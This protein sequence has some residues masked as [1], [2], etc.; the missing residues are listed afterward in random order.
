MLYQP[1]L[2]TWAYPSIC[3]VLG[4][5]PRELHMAGTLYWVKYI[6]IKCPLQKEICKTLMSLCTIWE[7]HS[8]NLTLLWALVF[9]GPDSNK[10]LS[11]KQTKMVS[12]YLSVNVTTRFLGKE[13]HWSETDGLGR[14]LSLRQAL[15]KQEQAVLFMWTA[16]C[17]VSK[18]SNLKYI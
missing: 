5:F 8:V 17:S 18:I 2:A 10:H 14:I 7:E 12:P 6:W 9:H 1:I 15:K 13:L 3:T 16:H 11:D 4:S